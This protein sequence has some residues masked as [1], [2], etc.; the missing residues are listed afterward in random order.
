MK[1]CLIALLVCG[2]VTF[3]Q[4]VYGPYT[5]LGPPADDYVT[6][7]FVPL[8]NDEV[9]VF[10]VDANTVLQTEYTL[11]QQGA[12]SPPRIIGGGGDSSYS[13][14]SSASDFSGSES[15][16]AILV[17]GKHG[18]YERYHCIF[19]AGDTSENRSVGGFYLCNP[20]GCRSIFDHC[21]SSDFSGGWDIVL[22]SAGADNPIGEWNATPYY[23]NASSASIDSFRYVNCGFSWEHCFSGP[24]YF[25]CTQTP[26]G[27]LFVY[28][29]GFWTETIVLFPD[30]LAMNDPFEEPL[31]WGLDCPV[32]PFDLQQTRGSRLIAFSGR[33]EFPYYMS[34][35]APQGVA[36][37]DTSG[38]CE[39]VELPEIERDPDALAFHPDY[40]WAVLLHNQNYIS[41]ATVDTNGT[42]I[43]E[44]GILYWHEGESAIMDADIALTDDGK[45]I[46]L[47]SERDHWNEP[48]ARLR[49]A[50]TTWDTQL[51]AQPADRVSLPETVALSAYPNPFNSEVRIAYSLPQ[52]DDIDLTV[53]N[54]QGQVVER[55]IDERTAAGEHELSWQPQ[56]TSGVYFVRLQTANQTQTQK[57][58]YLK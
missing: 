50:W 55:L 32:A 57:I 54:L 58:L 7:R 18:S 17:C 30:S 49:A 15:H 4:P 11:G 46:V 24:L 48:A 33:E 37:F 51:A 13:I 22:F 23:A 2:C 21:V 31:H 10:Y 25:R 14:V 16:W 3:A 20:D 34:D 28:E 26:S 56:T 40:G 29:A 42:L 45:V 27:P 1:H 41:V 52:A 5:V 44:P 36:T 39:I 12:S 35:D 43:T 38:Y 6:P 47:W 53:Y 8:S 9:A 19:Q